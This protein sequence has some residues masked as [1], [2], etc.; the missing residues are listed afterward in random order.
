MPRLNRVV[1]I[2]GLLVL[3][4][5]L[6]GFLYLTWDGVFEPSFVS[7]VV[8]SMLVM[9]TGISVFLTLLLLE[10]NRTARQREFEPSF[11]V[12]LEPVAIGAF[13]VVLENI[14]NGPAKDVE[15]TLRL[16]PDEIEWKFRRQN[17]RP[18]DKAPAF[19]SEED[20]VF[21]QESSDEFDKITVQGEC[22]DV[23]GNTVEFSDA[24]DMA[25]LRSGEY[26]QHLP[27]EDRL[28]QKVDDIASNLRDINRTLEQ[29]ER[30]W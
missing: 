20:I 14:G 28:E 29:F 9:V 11:T 6:T 26:T 19:I 5:I 3:A 27:Y 18:G 30:D 2:L 1:G 12:Y 22:T 16:Y 21:K 23:F 24:Y 8:T 10:E 25:L 15:A 17:V 4:G 13:D 7:A